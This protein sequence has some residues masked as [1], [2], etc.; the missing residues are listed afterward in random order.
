M[1]YGID[2]SEFQGAIDW[3][4][5]AVR[6]RAGRLDFI[7]MRAGY[8]YGGTD[9]RFAENYA[10]A[11][12]AGIPVGAYWYAY[13]SEASPRAEAE[14]FLAAI[15]GK[16]LTYG[17]WYDVE[18]EPAILNL[19]RA[20]RT[21]KTLEAL[22]TLAA[23]G[24]YTGLYAST[25]MINNR[26]DYERLRGYDLWAAQYAA[27]NTSRLPYGIW[28]YTDRGQIA[29]IAT[30]VDCDIA[31]KDYPAFVTG[32]LAGETEE[33]GGTPEPNPQ[34]TRR[35][36]PMTRGDLVTMLNAAGELGV[37]VT[38]EL[39]IGPASTGD[40]KTL[41]ALADSLRLPSVEL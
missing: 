24:R 19:S 37:Y 28:Q 21:D 17:V 23:S 34:Y 41:R 32:R 8:G 38:G 20:E 15:D 13:W 39:T 6:H 12:A 29:G 11:T 26:M 4:Q 35:Y 31:Y 14:S 3:E 7:I 18:Y 1:K 33:G 9:A 40:D 25:D 22:D 10:A 27:A 30:R 5:L 36:G 16:I 2:I